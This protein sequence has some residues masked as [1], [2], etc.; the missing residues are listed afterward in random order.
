MCGSASKNKPLAATPAPGPGTEHE[1]VGNG[2]PSPSEQRC[3]L[4]HKSALS[5]SGGRRSHKRS[6][7]CA[8]GRGRGLCSWE[9]GLSAWLLR[10]P[11]R[12]SWLGPW[13]SGDKE[14]TSVA[15]WNL[16]WTEVGIRACGKAVRVV[17]GGFLTS[18]GV[19]CLQRSGTLVGSRYK[20][21]RVTDR[22]SSSN[23]NSCQAQGWNHRY[24]PPPSFPIKSWAFWTR[25]VSPFSLSPSFS[26]LEVAWAGKSTRFMSLPGGVTLGKLLC[27]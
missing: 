19:V 13:A 1:I 9:R 26:F 10:W 23:A 7:C 21:G 24:H 22:S 27:F 15:M 18:L 2:S 16:A 8:G 25:R 14:R 4:Q 6:L 17:L 12:C 5:R 20:V 11:Q 3:F